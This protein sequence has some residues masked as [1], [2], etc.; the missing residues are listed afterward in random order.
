MLISARKAGLNF[1]RTLMLGRQWLIIDPALLRYFAE[2]LG[3]L[4]AEQLKQLD[5]E[6]NGGFSEGFLKF[7]GANDVQSMDASDYE[8]ATIIH[9]LN[10][11]V[12]AQL[13][14]RFDVVIDGGTIEHV[15]N[16]PVAIKN[17]MEMVKVGGR[18]FLFTPANNFMGHGLYQFSPELLYRV[19]SESN[20]FVVERML[21]TEMGSFEYHDVVDPDS[22]KERVALVNK[23]PLTLIVQAKRISA[24]PIFQKTPQ[25][26]DYVHNWARETKS[27][28]GDHGPFLDRVR[29]GVISLIPPK[30]RLILRRLIWEP[31]RG[32]TRHR[33]LS[34]ANKR[35]FRSTSM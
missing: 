35:H 13:H 24:V 28:M 16:Y 29:M 20:G 18:L 25:Q 27:S 12:P 21:V 4:S 33:D 19:L 5:P 11:P 22:L 17:A 3:A 6:A 9:D 1:T 34:L 32:R 26:S 30:A 15:F 8:S 7:L 23:K 10:Q 14:Q 2:R 31:I